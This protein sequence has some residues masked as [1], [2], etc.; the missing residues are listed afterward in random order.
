MQSDQQARW[1]PS[2]STPGDRVRIRELWRLS[3]SAVHST[4]RRTDRWRPRSSRMRCSSWTLSGRPWSASRTG[5]RMAT[6]KMLTARPWVSSVSFGKCGPTS[7]ALSA[8]P[9]GGTRL[10]WRG[11][12]ADLD[13]ARPARRLPGIPIWTGDA[14]RLSALSTRFLRFFASRG[15][16]QRSIETYEAIHGRY[17]AFLIRGWPTTSATSRPILSRPSPRPRPNEA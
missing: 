6:F 7:S 14:M 13:N 10:G 12:D 15:A 16:S 2:R 11:C 4:E 8:A 17:T 9:V 3:G 1:H 5:E